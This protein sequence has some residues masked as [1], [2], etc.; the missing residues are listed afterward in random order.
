MGHLSELQV[1]HSE[2]L[3]GPNGEVRILSPKWK[4]LVYYKIDAVTPGDLVVHSRRL[5]EGSKIIPTYHN[6]LCS[7]SYRRRTSLSH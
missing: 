3:R 5:V 2:S 4:I 1:I 6:N 7:L